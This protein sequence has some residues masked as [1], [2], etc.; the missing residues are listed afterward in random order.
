MWRN[1]GRCGRPMTKRMGADVNVELL[2]PAGS[3]E[4]LQSAFYFG[5]DA[6]YLAGRQYSLRAFAKNFTYEDLKT[7]VDYAKLRNKKVYLTANA[8]FHNRDFDGFEDFLHTVDN[9]GVDALI[10]SDPGVLYAIKETLPDMEIH[11]STQANTTNSKSARFWHD[12]GVKRVILARELSLDEIRQIRENTPDT[13][14]LE[15]FVHGA[16]CISYSGRCLLSGVLTG[17]HANAGEC[18]HPCRYEYYL[19]EKGHEGEFFPVMEDNRGTYILNSKDMMLIEHLAKLKDAGV[20]SFKIEGRM[21]TAYYVATAVNAYRHAIDEMQ[22]GKP[23]DPIWKEELEKAGTR[24][25]TTGF[26]FGNPGV[27]AQDIGNT[28]KKATHIF[29]AKVL[30]YDP[31]N[32]LL[33]LEQRNRFFIGDTLEILAPDVK[34]NLLAGRIINEDGAEQQSAPHPQQILYIPSDLALKEGDMLRKRL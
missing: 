6:V 27:T 18:A 11:L 5:A 24:E 20:S 14:A 7:A 33:K 31:V 1:T 28:K 17:R 26:L 21:K 8:F 2:A 16:M 23:F 3:M 4:A 22:K 29:A 12:A 32:R 19:Y 30:G 13:L 10:V 34:G 25:F 15:A 9:A